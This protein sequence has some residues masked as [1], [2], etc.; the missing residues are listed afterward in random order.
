LNLFCILAER[1]S[2]ENLLENLPIVLRDA[3]EYLEKEVYNSLTGEE[4]L[5]LQ[6]IAVFRLSET[7]DAFD[8]VNEFKDLNGTLNSLIHKFLV[9]EIGINTYSIHEIIRDYCLSDVSKRKILKSYHERAVEHYLSLDGDPEHVLEASY[10]FA[11]AGKKEK[12]AEVIINNAGDLIA[13]GFWKKIENRIQSAIKSFR[14]KTQTHIIQLVARA[15]LE[16]GRLYEEKGDY[17]LALH[18]A[19]QSLNGFQDREIGDKK[20][21]FDSN[22]L[23]AAIYDDKNEIE[24]AIEFNEKCLKM[25]EK[26]NND[27]WKAVAMG[28]RGN[29]LGKENKDLKLDYYLKSLKIFEDQNSVSNISAACANLAT[30]YEEMGNYEKSYKFIKRAL[31]LTKERNAF[32]DIAKTKEMMANIY[33]NDP[34]KPVSVDSIINCLKEALE[35]YEKIGH[36]RGT[37]RVLTEIGDIHLKEEDF[38]SAITNYQRAVTI[39]SSVNQQSEEAKL[40]TKIG[41]C[42]VKL[43]D[44]PNAKSY[45]EKYLLSGHCGI[46]D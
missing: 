39:Y 35:T 8:N 30:V 22:N 23:I 38:E 7:V 26:Q 19:V 12:S 6:T 10:H 41:F 27:H 14:R 21:I 37:A 4:K 25:A 42:Y 43:K 9:N 18:H 2:A 1:S 16:I 20:G 46:G 33:Y 40:N 15:N 34:E 28:T 11:E 5:L 17:N 3:R 36:V 24:K 13:Q 44:F 32:Y 45:F 29:L 31:E